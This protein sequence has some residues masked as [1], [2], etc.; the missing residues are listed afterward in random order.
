MKM[1]IA[2]IS[3]NSDIC[4]SFRRLRSSLIPRDAVLKGSFGSTRPTYFIKSFNPLVTETTVEDFLRDSAREVDAIIFLVEMHLLGAIK[5]IRSAC[6]VAPLSFETQALNM[7]NYFGAVF[8][9]I[10]RNF[11][12]ILSVMS[13]SDNEQLMI[14][15]IR[16]FNSASLQQLNYI[17]TAESMEPTLNNELGNCVTELRKKKHPRRNT[18]D[19]TLYVVDDDQKYFE[20]GKER[21]SKLPTGSPHNSACEINGNFRFG[22]RIATDRHFNVTKLVGASTKIKGTFPNCHDEYVDVKETT[23]LNMFSNDAF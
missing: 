16:N 18:R 3:S 12:T 19:R 4:K 2:L 15:P 8:A 13:S 1:L 21:H 11:S 20:Y 17:C 22:K 6:F 9:R 23:H 14:L 10:F 5:S 7:H